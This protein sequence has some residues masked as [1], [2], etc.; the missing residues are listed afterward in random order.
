[1]KYKRAGD[2]YVLKLEPG[3]EIHASVAEFAKKEKIRLA[4]VAAIGSVT[5][6]TIGYYSVRTK[7]YYRREFH[8]EFEI[9]GC[10]GTRRWME[11]HAAPLRD[12][13]GNVFAQLAVTRDVTP[14]KRA[15][16]ALR[17][18][19]EKRSTDPF[20]RR[21]WRAATSPSQTERSSPATLPS[22]A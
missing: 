14:R 2:A 9:V 5:D 7:E 21:T 1:M 18:S 11:T 6:P 16:E 17:A 20:S 8:G 15:E 12:A 22:P 4:A 3:D 19:E 13:L 10:K